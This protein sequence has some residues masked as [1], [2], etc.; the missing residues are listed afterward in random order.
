MRYI[1]ANQKPLIDMTKEDDSNRIDEM[2]AEVERLNEV[3]TTLFYKWD[4]KCA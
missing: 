2:E 3:V 1:Q 4:R